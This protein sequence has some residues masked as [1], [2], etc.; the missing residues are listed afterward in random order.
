M[1]LYPLLRPL[2]FQLD[3]ETAHNLTL[4]GL[5]R[6]HALGLLKPFLPSVAPSP[7]RVMGLDFSN[8]V[9][10][11]AGL[12]KNGEAI[13]ALAALGFGFL[14]LGAVTPRPQPGNPKPRLFRLPDASAIIN[15]MGFN[16]LGVDHL[17]RNL[18]TRDYR[19]ILGVNLG[20]NLDTPIE[21]AADD[22]LILLNKLYGKVDFVT[23]NISSPNTKNLRALQG[24][25]EL[26]ALLGKIKAEQNRL[27]QQHGKYMP[28]AVKIAPDL[29][30]AQIADM[31][32]LM[33]KHHVDALIATNTTLARD[34]VAHLAHGQ[35]TGGLSGAPL[36]QKA[37]HVIQAFHDALAGELPI[38]GAGGI[39][40]GNDAR[41][42][43]AAGA[44]LLQIY[45]GLIYR[46]PE[47]IRECV[48]AT[49]N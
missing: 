10:M 37:T 24:G 23:I 41:E 40:E 33:R 47:L 13:D 18:E 3:P 12:D 9:G 11:A 44:E 29:D 26:D 31:A 21:R 42:K 8:P 34:G 45:S 5:R 7:R 36:R 19:G 48:E 17:L 15:R 30:A 4:S 35:E 25:D 1:N 16:N 49:R 32:A 46:G 27:A 38:I 6:L 43:M 14:E 39:L 20:K 22:Y 2:L 28:V